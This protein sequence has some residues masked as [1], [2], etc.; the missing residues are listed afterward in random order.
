MRGRLW[1]SAPWWVGAI[2]HCHCLEKLLCGHDESRLTFSQF[3]IVFKFSTVIATPCCLYQGGTNHFL[4]APKHT[5][6]LLQKRCYTLV[7]FKTVWARPCVLGNNDDKSQ[8]KYR[9]YGTYNNKSLLLLCFQLYWA[10]LDSLILKLVNGVTKM[11]FLRKRWN[12]ITLL[13]KI[14]LLKCLKF[15]YWSLWNKRVEKHVV[16]KSLKE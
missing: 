12:I 8:W 13:M 14:S 6:I 10:I 1:S 16:E 15:L 5:H 7:K 2:G 4:P 9:S 11:S 3:A